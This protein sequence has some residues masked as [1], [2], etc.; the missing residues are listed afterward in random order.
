VK[1]LRFVVGLTLSYPLAAS[2]GDLRCGVDPRTDAHQCFKQTEL[3]EVDGIRFAPLYSGGPKSVDRTNFTVHANCATRV[4]HLKDR[5][6]V[7][8]AG[9]SFDSTELSR[10]LGNEV[11]SA[12][13]R[14]SQK[15]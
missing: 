1:T 9:G 15:K 7:S 13:L 4:L 12:G 14:P 3:R 2:A 5:K 6:G 8:F 11:C 10:S